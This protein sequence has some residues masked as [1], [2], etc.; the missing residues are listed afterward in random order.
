MGIGVPKVVTHF[1]GLITIV[2][3]DAIILAFSISLL[4]GIV[5]GIYPA[6]RAAALSPIDALRHE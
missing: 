3:P 6:I 5:F 2:Q 4:I 1:A